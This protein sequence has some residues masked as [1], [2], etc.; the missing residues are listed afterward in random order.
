MGDAP[1][2]SIRPS[3]SRTRVAAIVRVLKPGESG[4]LAAVGEGGAG[5]TFQKTMLPARASPI[6]VKKPAPNTT[7]QTQT[8]AELLLAL[9]KIISL[10]KKPGSG[11]KP[12]TDAAA[13]KVSRP[14]V[15][16]CATGMAGSSLSLASPRCDAMSSTSK[17]SAATTSVLWTM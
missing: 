12:A 11:G 4:E 10:P 13:S 1:T 7:D 2:A 16:G 14:S 9:C 8:C 5:K 17:K 3:A 15:I 6:S